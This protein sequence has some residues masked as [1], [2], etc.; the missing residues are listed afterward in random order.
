MRRMFQ[1]CNKLK[2]LNLNFDTS[3]VI[4]MEFMFNLCNELKE[5]KGI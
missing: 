1:S 5:I 3:N 4:N 2:N